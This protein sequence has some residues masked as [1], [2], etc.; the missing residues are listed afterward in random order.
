MDQF[1]SALN[2]AGEVA[3]TRALVIVDAINEGGGLDTWPPHLRSLAAEISKYSHVGFVVSCRSSYVQVLLSSEPEASGPKDLG[4]I[5]VKHTGFV[6]RE[7]KA[8]G[9][10]FSHW[11]LTIPDFPLLVPEYSNPLFLKLLCQS[12]NQAGEKT[13]PRGATGITALFERF[14]R[15]A[16]RRLS[17]P[18]PL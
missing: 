15:E 2:T 11:E 9:T 6:D 14:L 16:N 13:L 10:F 3:G 18:S 1:L 5:E 17:G 8:A 7:W 4:F 12:L